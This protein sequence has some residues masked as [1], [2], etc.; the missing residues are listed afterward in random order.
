M[1]A[2]LRSKP[3]VMDEDD[4]RCERPIFAPWSCGTRQAFSRN[5]TDR[6][7]GTIGEARF[8]GKRYTWAALVGVAHHRALQSLILAPLLSHRCHP[9]WQMIRVTTLRQLQ[10]WH[11][12]RHGGM[13]IRGGLTRSDSILRFLSG[14]SEAIMLPI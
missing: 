13:T 9:P 3:K 4:S 7:M 11:R 1:R 5:T 8:R 14:T 6:G 2:E 10:A 12:V